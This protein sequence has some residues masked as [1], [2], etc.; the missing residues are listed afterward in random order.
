MSP[1]DAALAGLRVLIAQIVDEALAKRAPDG[2]LRRPP[3]CRGNLPSTRTG[4]VYAIVLNFDVE[5]LRMKIGYTEK[6]VGARLSTIRTTCPE[7]RIVGTWDADR[8]DE[9]RAHRVVPGR[10]GKSEVF[11][12]S[13]DDAADA[14]A[15]I[16]A[17]IA[18]RIA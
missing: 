3:H 16:G 10:I 7:A 11:A 17:A 6:Q 18:E 1:T 15:A 8:H 9:E 4:W 2:E 14:L 12:V 13:I 5:P